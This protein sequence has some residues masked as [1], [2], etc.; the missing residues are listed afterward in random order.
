M[1]IFIGL[2]FHRYTAFCQQAAV[3]EPYPVEDTLCRYVAYL[4]NQSLKHRTIKA[5]LSALRFA[6]VHQGLGD[7]FRQSPMP[8][9]EYVLAGIKRS[10]AKAYTPPKPR[11]PITPD[12]LARLRE[13]WVHNPPPQDGYMLW[14]AACTGFFGFLRAGEFTVPSPGSYDKQV[15]LNLDDLAIDS[16]STPSMV[17]IHIKQSKTDPFRQ[18]TDVYLGAT[19]T[20]LCPVQALW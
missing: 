16:H 13:Q 18:G 1:R 4:S 20:P 19:G 15:H 10:Q 12:I 8:L 9:L 14:A 5:Y 7:P 11:L 2:A 6:Q 17:R 3:R